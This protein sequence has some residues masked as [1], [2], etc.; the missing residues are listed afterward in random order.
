MESPS[1]KPPARIRAVTKPSHAGLR[2]TLMAA[3]RQQLSGTRSARPARPH[4]GA[5]RPYHRRIALLVTTLAFAATTTSAQA[6]QPLATAKPKNSL[7]VILH[8]LPGGA[9][10]KATVTG[11]K[12]SPTAT[13]GF[14]RI[15][16]KSA[17]LSGLAAGTYTITV[18]DVSFGGST[19]RPDKPRGTAKVRTSGPTTFKATYAKVADAAGNPEPVTNLVVT[20]GVSKLTV[21]WVT[22]MKRAAAYTLSASPGGATCT[23]VKSP[24]DITGLS[25]N[26]SYT[27][28]VTASNGPSKSVT[29]TSD[30]VTPLRNGQV[31]VDGYVLGPGVNLAGAQLVGSRL[32]GVNLTGANLSGADLTGANLSGADLS[33]TNLAGAILT[34]STLKSVKSGSITGT[35]TGA[36]PTGWILAKGH[37]V[38]PGANLT[39]ADLSDSD[40]TGARLTGALMTSANLTN[41]DL[42]AVS[43]KDLR[44]VSFYGASLINA[45]L[46]GLDLTGAVLKSVRMSGIDLSGANLTNAA[47]NSATLSNANLSN[48]TFTG[49]DL[50]SATLT[51]ANVTGAALAGAITKLI[52][53]CGLVG[54]PREV[55]SASGVVSGCYVSPKANLSGADFTG[56]D[57][58]GLSMSGANLASVVFKQANLTGAIL[59]GATITNADFTSA[60][61]TGLQ[62][63]GLTGAPKSSTLPVG[64]QFDA[65]T[66]TIA[67][68]IP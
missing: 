46:A 23:A 56:A 68:T 52:N 5:V 51:G 7:V 54:Q 18:Q 22:P 58:H 4:R 47:L 49:A 67:P 25:W 43:G 41:A 62:A 2:Q 13:K 61:L 40:L 63:T 65:K 20:P 48:A 17:T 26:T 27:V 53:A 57:L 34:A 19:Y 14:S 33:Y 11:P 66:G 32:T 24:C 38:G 9:V 37:L 45:K 64:W 6:S 1:L 10:P 28:T 8:G 3:Y 31:F 36:L 30:A 21:R 42:R 55:A 16:R 59:T 50:S 15:L 44:G 35:P 60:T 39:D 29:T 12:Q